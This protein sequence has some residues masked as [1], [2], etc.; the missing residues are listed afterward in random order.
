MSDNILTGE[1]QIQTV[2]NQHPDVDSGVMGDIPS[3]EIRDRVDA[4]KSVTLQAPT[5]DYGLPLYIYRPDLIQTN[6]DALPAAE[7]AQVLEAASVDVVY[8][9]GFPAFLDGAAFW[10]RMDFEPDDAYYAFSIYLEM[11]DRKGARRLE[12]LYYELANSASSENQ[13]HF[14]QAALLDGNARRRIKESFV[15]YNWGIRCKAY[16]LFKVAAHHKLRERRIVSTTDRHFLQ[17]EKLMGK[18]ETYFEKV[19]DETG[20]LAWL[21]DLK[22]TDAINILDKLVKI[23]RTSIGLSAHG[24]SGGE[25]GNLSSNAETETILRQ[26]ATFAQDPNAEKNGS[27]TSDLSVLLNDPETAALAQE[28]VIKVS[29]SQRESS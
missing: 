9:E 22:A 25:G 17:A 10:S 20:D 28:L 15:F 7:K 14:S 16:D 1:V 29:E 13:T 12:D 21:T 2:D 3:M 11:G 6:I 4:F 23:Q 26:L 19:D 8:D 24:L 27:L 5:N 18:V